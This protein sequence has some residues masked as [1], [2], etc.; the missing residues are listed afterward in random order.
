MS[1]IIGLSVVVIAVFFSIQ[2]LSLIIINRRPT[3]STSNFETLPKVSILLAARNEEKLIKRNLDAISNLNYPSDKLEVLIGNDDST[4]A[5][6]QIISEFIADKPSFKLFHVSQRLG[7]ARGKANVLAHL[8]HQ[9]SGEFYFITDVDV[10]LPSK[11]IKSLIQ[12]FDPDVGIVSGTSTC[13][14][15]G[16]TFSIMQSVDWLH[17]MGYIQSFANIGI[18]CTSVGNNMAVRANCYWETGGYEHI[19]FS[20]TEDYKLFKEVTSRG[21]AWRTTLDSESLGLAYYIPTLFEMWHQRK[22]WLI[23]SRELPILWKFLI[24]LYGLFAPALVVLAIFA[25]LHALCLWLLKLTVQSIYINRL[26]T[27]VG[28]PHFK[29]SHLLQYEIYLVVNTVCTVAFYFLPIQSVWKGRTYH[30]S[31]L[32]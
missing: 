4:D 26:S 24:I 1:I 22:R 8:A 21:W 3:L 6:A 18:A 28:L 32:S 16:T 9:A 29:V 15:I 7:K 30:K 31:D 25:P 10:K 11:W 14:P 5:T 2:V 17:F 20:I 27:L 13:E 12:Q 23:G 19:D